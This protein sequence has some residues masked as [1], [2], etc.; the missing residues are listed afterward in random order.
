MPVVT[1]S[2]L[3]S[4]V[5]LPSPLPSPK[6]LPSPVATPSPSPSASPSVKSEKLDPLQSGVDYDPKKV[7]FKVLVKALENVTVRYKCDD[8][9]MMQ[10]TLKKD[11]I[12]VLR[13]LET[14][15][16]QASNP[17]AVTYSPNGQGYRTMA[18]S[19]NQFDAGETASLVWP[20]QDR[21]KLKENFKSQPVLPMT[22]SP[23]ESTAPSPASDVE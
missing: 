19:A 20:L 7:K 6:I 22:P 15:Y 16:F 10:F 13:G 4:P 23:A 2:V 3:P 8:K 18:S 9:K 14:V 5:V 12:L 17:E 11:R 21:E 1:H